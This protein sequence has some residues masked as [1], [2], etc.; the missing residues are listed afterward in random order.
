M[1][2]GPFTWMPALARAAAFA[3]TLP[4]AKK[5]RALLGSLACVLLARRLTD[6]TTEKGP[7]AGAVE[8][9]TFSATDKLPGDYWVEAGVALTKPKDDNVIEFYFRKTSR[10]S[11]RPP[12]ASWTRPAIKAFTTSTSL[13]SGSRS[14]CAGTRRSTRTAVPRRPT[15]PR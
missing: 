1:K 10:S 6:A 9:L 4:T 8:R 5:R 7:N 11:A 13:R 15:S 12:C 3:M 14:T 2:T